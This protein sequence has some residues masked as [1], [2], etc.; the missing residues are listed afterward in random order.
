MAVYEYGTK[1][2]TVR[3]FY[4]TGTTNGFGGYY[5]LFLGDQGSLEIS[6]SGARA[7][8]YRDV[9]NAP[10]WGSFVKRGLLMA[11]VQEVK[12][13]PDVV[14][15]VRETAP[16][17]SYALPIQSLKLYHQPHLE[18]FFD[19]VRGRGRLNCPAEVGFESA[20]TVLKVNEAIEAN[21][22]LA[23]EAKDFE[24]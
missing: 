21:R 14:L 7:K 4:Q 9:A 24:I 13:Q 22:P 12:P 20:V 15:D 8:V 23:F 3:A 6:E 5:E 17:P 11:P 19:A 10:D 2:G 1:N 16:P 18:N